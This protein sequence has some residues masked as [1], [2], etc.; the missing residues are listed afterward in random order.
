MRKYPRWVDPA[1]EFAADTWGVFK[2]V[3]GLVVSPVGFAL[4]AWRAI[5]NHTLA[6]QRVRSFPAQLAALEAGIDPVPPAD[7][8]ERLSSHLDL[9]I[10][11]DLHRCFPGRRDWLERQDV[12]DLYAAVLDLA[13]DAGRHV[14]ENGDIDD[15]WMVGGSPYGQWYD[16]A[17]VVTHFI[18]GRTGLE[19][20]RAIY[21]RH[22]RTIVANHPASYKRL[23]LLGEAGRYHRTVGNHDD[24]YLDRALADSLSD[25]VGGIAIC[26][27]IVLED[28][29]GEAVAFITHGHQTDGWNAPGRA[30]LGKLATWAGN[31]LSDTPGLEAPD[32]VPPRS[33]TTA[34]L[35]GQLP[36][37]LLRVSKRFGTNSKYD[38]LD[39]ELL[40]DAFGGAATNGPW[41]ILGHTHLPVLQPMSR[42][43]V[44][45]ERYANSGNGIWDGMITGLEG[46][47]ASTNGTPTP[48]M[49]AWL[50]ADRH[51]LGGLVTEADVVAHHGGRPVA[52]IEFERTPDGA[53]LRPR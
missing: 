9:L 20:R 11:S 30:Y 42:S 7:R 25:L 29:A 49:V 1:A 4:V 26:D 46:D 43:G 38:S 16:A 22:L 48:K 35:R 45:W 10:T 32:T 8:V 17:R 19:L 44:A 18:P 21:R 50:W 5:H 52:R 24:V 51:D 40:F 3:V 12:K 36:N 14:V 27:V 47:G 13:T 37:R 2:F 23:Q 33:L 6:K 31:T 28:H 39:E 15:Y 53:H 34:F 41:I